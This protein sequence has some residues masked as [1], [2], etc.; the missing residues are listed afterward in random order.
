[1]PSAIISNPNISVKMLPT[2]FRFSPVSRPY[3]G[4]FSVPNPETGELTAVPMNL[5]RIQYEIYSEK[6]EKIVEG[7]PVWIDFTTPVLLDTNTIE[8]PNALH[9]LIENYLE[10]PTTALLE[11]INA[12]I[13][14]FVFQNSMEGFLL[15]VENVTMN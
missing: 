12:Q 15:H 9:L 5:I 8:I 4:T 7:E 10:T 2:R 14:N 13:G 3:A 11:T 6:W 1:M